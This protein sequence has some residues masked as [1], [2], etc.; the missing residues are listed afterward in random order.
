MDKD[1]FQFLFFRHVTIFAPCLRHLALDFEGFPS[2]EE[3]YWGTLV[4]QIDLAVELYIL[5]LAESTQ[6]RTNNKLGIEI[7]GVQLSSG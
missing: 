7:V 3:Y 2:C 5:F 6:F 4:L 1:T